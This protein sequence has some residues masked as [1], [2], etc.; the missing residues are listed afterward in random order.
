M[1]QGH[2]EFLQKIITGENLVR[3]THGDHADLVRIHHGFAGTV[4]HSAALTLQAAGASE[5]R[6]FL[7]NCC[8]RFSPA[9]N[10]SCCKSSGVS[11]S[12]AIPLR[13]STTH[14]CPVP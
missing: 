2:P 11:M 8:D 14:G 7:A 3:K 4:A 6:S 13:V 1:P 12:S 10:A 5:S 9:A